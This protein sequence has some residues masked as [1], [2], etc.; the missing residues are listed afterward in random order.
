[1]RNSG[2]RNVLVDLLSIY[3]PTVFIVIGVS[4]VS[5]F[6]PIYASTFGVSYTLAASTISIFAVA[7]LLSN[8]PVGLL[9]DRFG[10][11]PVLLLGALVTAFSGFLCAYSSTF[12]ELLFYRFFQGIGSS[13]W[14]TMRVTMLQDILKP[15]ERG[16][17]LSYFQAFMLIGSSA[18]PIIGGIIAQNWGLRA[19]FLAY[20]AAGLICF[21]L[22]FF[23]IKEAEEYNMV[24]S[25]YVSSFSFKLVKKLLKNS[26]FCA[27]CIGFFI[28]FFLRN[29]LKS[30]LIPLYA[31]EELNL[32]NVE[33]GYAISLSTLTTLFMTIPIGHALDKFGRKKVLVPSLVATSIISIFFSFTHNFPELSLMCLLLGLG[34]VGGQAPLALAADATMNEPHGLAMGVFRV[35]GDWGFVAGPIIVGV[36]ADACDLVIPFYIIAL[37]VLFSA[38]IIQFVAKESL[39]IR[40][41]KAKP[42]YLKQ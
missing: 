33:I 15:K 31:A 35:F 5:P 21:A 32:N 39:K 18:G 23:L 38:I 1:M 9:G 36:I 16:R 20:A 2:K 30:T 29:S 6:I 10:R 26:S 17:I 22:S 42:R 12:W 3:L 24:K 11:R 19:P 14:Q 7:R 25:Q 8:V 13:M 27:A 41:G 34:T 28:V 4:I 37:I 40:E